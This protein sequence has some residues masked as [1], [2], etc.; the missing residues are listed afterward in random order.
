MRDMYRCYLAAEGRWRTIEFRLPSAYVAQWGGE[1]DQDR[2]SERTEKK[3][4]IKTE[5]FHR[6]V[7]DM[8]GYKSLARRK[9]KK[10]TVAKM[11]N[12]YLHVF[13]VSLWQIEISAWTKKSVFFYFNQFEERVR[14]SCQY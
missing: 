2:K 6:W 9:K 3:S 7:K 12:I 10:K 4:E 14:S 8:V 11:Y 1:E 13:T 5:S